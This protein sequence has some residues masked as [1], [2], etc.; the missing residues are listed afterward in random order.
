MGR[1]TLSEPVSSWLLISLAFFFALAVVIFL[2]VGTYTRHESVQGQ[3]VPSAGLFPVVAR[4]A[5]TVIGKPIREGAV[6]KK[7][8]ILVELSGEISSASKG[9]TQ[10]AVIADLQ[11]QLRELEALVDNQ[12]SQENQERESLGGRI[13]LLNRELAEVDRQFSNQQEQTGL[14]ERRME[15]LGPGV[16]DGTFSQIELEKY[17]SE[18]LNGRAQLNVLARLRLEREQQLTLLQD[19]LQRLPLTMES[20]R[21]ELRVRISSINQSLA[22]NEVQRATVL[23]AACDGVATNITVQ[24]GQTVTAGQ[25][26]LTIL[27]E[28]ASLEAELWLPSRAIGFLEAGNKVI[29]RYPAFPYQKFGQQTGRLS[30]ISRSATAAAELTQLLGRP[31]SEPLYRVTAQLDQQ[32]VGAYSKQERLRPGMIVDA[33]LLIDRRRLIEWV[34]EPLYS[35]GALSKNRSSKELIA[36]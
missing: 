5:G 30:E 6:V 31:I 18:A 8:Q 12:K 10:N 13:A 11:A 34:L 23:R 29:L 25:R 16:R 35:V 22:Q 14:A 1:I 19:Q 24:P 9:Q 27:P 26:L 28:G 21:T 17:Q 33:D 2:F 4:S 32:T 36:E 7:D 3:L 20:Q 15:K